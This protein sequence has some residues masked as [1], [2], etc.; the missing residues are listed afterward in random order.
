MTFRLAAAALLGVASLGGTA[1][2]ADLL[3]F[4]SMPGDYI[5]QGVPQ[6][7]TADDAAFDARRNF[8]N[9]VS[10]SVSAG[11][12]G[13]WSLDFAAPLGA[14]LAPGAYEGAT[15]F[16][17]QTPVGPGLSV[18]GDG[19]GCNTLTGRFTVLD[20]VYVPDGAVTTFSADFEQHCEGGAAAL[21]GSIRFHVGNGTCE[22]GDDGA[23]CDDGDAC[24]AA[25][26][27]EGGVCIGAVVTPCDATGQCQAAACDPVTGTCVMRARRDGAPC[28]DGDACTFAD[29]C[30]AGVCTGE[31]GAIDCEDGNPCTADLCHDGR[32]DFSQ[33]TVC[34]DDGD[35]CTEE[36]CDAVLGCTSRRV[37]GCCH[38]NAD[39]VDGDA[40]TEDICGADGR[41]VSHPL[42]CWTITGQVSATA[43]AAGRSAHATR[44]LT[45]VLVLGADGSYRAPNGVCPETGREFPDEVGVTVPG[46]RG[47]LVLKAT[48]LSAVSA[49][50]DDC[51]GRHLRLGVYRSWVKLLP[52]LAHLRGGATITASTRVRGVTV[53]LQVTERFRGTRVVSAPGAA[54]TGPAAALITAAP[55]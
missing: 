33:P 20:V 47:R 54:A 16:P 32:C 31:P 46:R 18:A 39:C 24:S 19:R 10:V 30:R 26:H 41:C 43:S 53:T 50:L 1:R 23:A 36:Y 49:A 13:A 21:F 28:D 14:P 38:T 7:F 15:R 12:R 5:G 17:F 8:D 37:P 27:C 22:P 3:F 45:G 29:G 44:R 52:D 11:Q 4:D 6:R 48:N 2:A 55:P 40:C 51:V 25:G 35:P 34:R 42:S 9:G